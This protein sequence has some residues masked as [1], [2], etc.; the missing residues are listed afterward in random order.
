MK[1]HGGVSVSR[2][3]P[4]LVAQGLATELGVQARLVSL[5]PLTEGF[6]QA[7]LDGRCMP[8]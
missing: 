2:F 7:G 6:E 1:T 8:P 3:W 5:E 4:D